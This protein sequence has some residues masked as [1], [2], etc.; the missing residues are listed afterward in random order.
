MWQRQSKSMATLIAFLLRRRINSAGCAAQ[1]PR[2]GPTTPRPAR[3][4]PPLCS[5][6]PPS[7]AER[8]AE[9]RRTREARVQR[10]ARARIEAGS[11]DPGQMQRQTE[12]RS[13]T[14]LLSRSS[15]AAAAI[16]DCLRDCFAR[17]H[18]TVVSEASRS[19]ASCSL[20]RLAGGA[21]AAA[22]RTRT[23]PSAILIAFLCGIC[24]F[25]ERS[26]FERSGR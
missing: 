22:Q 10:A 14:V 4:Y 1:L 6:A 26:W 2:H 16:A 21:N 3:S 8:A 11:T 18:S 9:R 23:K 20:A 24:G 15:C 17:R 19:S 7:L 12:C 5:P 13:N 25:T